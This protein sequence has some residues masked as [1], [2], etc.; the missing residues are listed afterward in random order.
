MNKAQVT[1]QL[2]LIIKINFS[3]YNTFVR[4]VFADQKNYE[5][6]KTTFDETFEYNF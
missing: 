2:A 4:L 6:E 5:G 1:I 3:F